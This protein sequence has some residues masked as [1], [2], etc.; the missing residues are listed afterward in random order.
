MLVLQRA[1]HMRRET[2]M[3]R[4]KKIKPVE[5]PE[6]A[7]K[8]VKQDFAVLPDGKIIEK[9]ELIKIKGEYGTV[10]KFRAFVTNIENGAQWID[11]IEMHRGQA[12]PFRAFRIDRVKKLPKK[13]GPRVRRT[14]NS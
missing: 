11:C 1:S 6:I 2:N 7:K 4:P 10:F 8:F 14:E 5:L 3:G 9:D 12:G 13:R